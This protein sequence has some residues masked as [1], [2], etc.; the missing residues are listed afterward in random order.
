MCGN[1]CNGLGD[2][3]TA[4]HKQEQA[5]GYDRESLALCQEFDHKGALAQC[6]P[7]FA[8]VASTSGHAVRAA[9]LC[10]AAASL[11][12]SIDASISS[13]PLDAGANYNRT[14]TA[15]RAQPDKAAFATIWAQGAR[16]R[17]IRWSPRY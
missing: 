12:E 1:A 5:K 9:L 16:C 17:W 4:L 10:R 15:V 13:L 8:T 11:L 14:I 7:G 2:V 6:L 3:A